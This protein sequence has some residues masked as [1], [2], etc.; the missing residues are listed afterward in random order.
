M[1][2]NNQIYSTNK[3]SSQV[4]LQDVAKDSVVFILISSSYFIALSS[5]TKSVGLIV[6]SLNFQE[7]LEL[8]HVTLRYLR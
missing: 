5:V 7:D 3:L 1:N 2:P 4:C 6:K 8:N